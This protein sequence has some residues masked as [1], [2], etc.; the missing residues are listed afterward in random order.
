MS[1]LDRIDEHLNEA[2]QK[3]VCPHCGRDFMMDDEGA[4]DKLNQIILQNKDNYFFKVGWPTKDGYGNNHSLELFFDFNPNTQVIEGRWDFAG[5][6][7]RDK[8]RT[9]LAISN[10]Q[11]RSPLPKVFIKTTPKYREGLANGSE[12]D[13]L[14][15]LN[16]KVN[17]KKLNKELEDLFDFR[18]YGTT[19][20]L[21]GKMQWMDL[22]KGK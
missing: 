1:I 16:S 8:S 20:N 15:L 22:R 9:P 21:A 13:V 17:F 11:M 12:K 10:M 6:G 4:A 18:K 5:G 3:I 2:S 19:E 7:F 14:N